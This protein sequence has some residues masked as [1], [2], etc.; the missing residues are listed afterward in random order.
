MEEPVSPGH[1]HLMC[2]RPWWGLGGFALCTYF[3]YTTFAGLRD[4]EFYWDSGWWIVLTWA[5]WVVFAAGLLTE[6]RCWREGIFFSLLL[7]VLLV[8]VVFSAWTSARP[9][10]IRE[11]REASLALWSLTAFASL[12]T[13]RLSKAR[14]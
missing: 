8:G 6:T 14:E 4:G 2:R 13:I 5:V 11:S 9:A 1:A 10:A 12:T 3:A 7:L